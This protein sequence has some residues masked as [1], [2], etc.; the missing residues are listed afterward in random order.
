MPVYNAGGYL[1]KAI[2]SVLAQSFSQFEL[3]LV[4]DGATDGSG[5]VCDR[6]AQQD[7]RVV[8]IHQKNGGIS[9]ARNRA[10][11]SARGEYIAFCD[12]DDEMLPQCLE[13]A[14][15]AIRS[16]RADMVKFTY[17]HD[18][19]SY[20]ELKW[21][22]SQ[23]FPDDAFQLDD[24]IDNYQ[25]FFAAICVLWNGMYTARIIK[26]NSISFDETV[27]FGME[28]FLFNLKYLEHVQTVAYISAKGYV[29]YDRYE[30]STDEKYN[31][32]KLY[33]REKAA[34]AERAFL[35]RRPV[36][37]DS[38]VR[39]Q[40]TYLSMY[41]TT[42]NHPDCDLSFR[43]KCGRLKALNTPQTLRLHCSRI[44]CLTLLAEPKQFLISMLFNLKLYSL[45]LRMYSRFS[46]RYKRFLD[47]QQERI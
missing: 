5:D 45:L 34:A 24:L 32:N 4:D 39:H 41:L 11:Q 2:E 44:Y 38:W 1:A 29:H 30:Q 16:K 43:E 19:L 23:S 42:L 22:S 35:E 7:P 28:D 37:K 20:G 21:S 31:E 47:Q 46:K 13:N 10:L 15:S 27:R 14:L 36:R 3:I 6:Y 40:A 33:A 18:R 26:D 12:H 9:S 17:Q 25:L 8:V